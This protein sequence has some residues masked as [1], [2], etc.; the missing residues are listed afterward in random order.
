MDVEV[1][2]AIDGRLRVD[3]EGIVAD[4]LRRRTRPDRATYEANAV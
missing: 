1:L 4:E 2:A 3:Q